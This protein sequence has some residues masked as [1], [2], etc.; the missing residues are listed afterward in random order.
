MLIDRVGGEMHS[1]DINPEY[2]EVSK[3]VVA[4]ECGD[5]KNTFHHVS[6]SVAFLKSFD[7]SID[8]LYL[9]SMDPAGGDDR[10]A[11]HQ[12]AEIEA[13]IDKMRPRGLIVLD[14]IRETVTEGKAAYS[15]PFMKAHGWTDVRL[16]PVSERKKR[17]KAHQG[18]IRRP[19]AI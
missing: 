4:R 14:D 16:I 5:L 11:R 8:L 7:R 17:H 13:A 9:D 10:A 3:S 6:D 2:I 1:V 19:K 15:V 18:I 12:L